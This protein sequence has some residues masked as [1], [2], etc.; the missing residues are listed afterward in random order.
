MPVRVTC[1]HALNWHHDRFKKSFVCVKRTLVESPNTGPM[2]TLQCTIERTP[3]RNHCACPQFNA[4]HK[5][6]SLNVGGYNIR[7]QYIYRKK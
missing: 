1:K 2:A 5:A 4:G 3:V 6:K 7:W